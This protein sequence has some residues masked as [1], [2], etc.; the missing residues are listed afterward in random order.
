MKPFK[1]LDLWASAAILF[2]P[3][4]KCETGSRKSEKWLYGAHSAL[5]SD[6]RICTSNF[7][8]NSSNLFLLFSLLLLPLCLGAQELQPRF[9]AGPELGADF[10]KISPVINN[11][12]NYTF[13]ISLEYPVHKF[14][15]GTALLYKEYGWQQYRE[16]TGETYQEVVKEELVTFHNYNE[17]NVKLNYYS[18][19]LRLQYRLPC[20]CVYVQAGIMADFANFGSEGNEEGVFRT[21]ED[22]QTFDFN[23]R[24]GLKPLNLTYELA[25]GFKLHFNE[26]W[27]MYMR[28][29]Y[30][31]MSQPSRQG[32]TEWASNYRSLHMAFGVQRAFF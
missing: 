6:F 27:R 9:I 24:T 18:I 31:I 8:F 4:L 5:Y 23:H 1:L 17:R 10:R 25:V 16:Y 30:R 13:G 21:V 26:K 2:E 29:T 28:P 7:T 12:S 11:N 22:P 15:L 19:P 32:S 3:S 20:N 14:S